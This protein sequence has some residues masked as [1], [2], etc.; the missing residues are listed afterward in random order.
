VSRQLDVLAWLA[1]VP[2]ALMARSGLRPHSLGGLF[3]KLFLAIELLWFLVAARHVAR[4]A[5]GTAVSSRAGGS[6]R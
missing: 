2:L 4:T 3:E 5:R 1:L 6:A